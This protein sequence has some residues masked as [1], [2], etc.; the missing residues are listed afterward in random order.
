MH[1]LAVMIAWMLRSSIR[2]AL[3]ALCALAGTTL[4]M[5]DPLTLT[6]A[7]HRFTPAEFTVPAGERFRIEVHNQ[8]STPAEFESSDLHVEKIIVPGGTISIMVGPLKPGTYKFFDDYHPDTAAGTI[9]AA[10][11]KVEK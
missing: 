2:V 8:D 6:I 9:T 4:A 1:T 7:D 5:T 10:E 11:Q 3:A